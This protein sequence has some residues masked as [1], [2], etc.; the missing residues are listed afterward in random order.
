MAFESGLLWELH[1]ANQKQSYLFGTIHLN[2]SI[3]S[4]RKLLFSK[5][6][7]SCD[8]FAAEVDLDKMQNSSL[9]SYFKLP[10][11]QNWKMTFKSNQ[12]DKIHSLASRIFKIDLNDFTEIYPLLLINQL[13][14][15]LIGRQNEYSID[16]LLW[17]MAEEK[18]IEKIG[19]EDFHEHFSMIEKIQL[20][21][22]LKMLKDLMRDLKKSRKLYL[23]MIE[24][25]Q[26]QDIRSIYQL[27]RKMLGKYRKLMLTDRN[28]L[29]S[30][31]ILDLSKEKS[32]FFS[33]GAGHLYG[34]F[35][36]L[37]LLK[38]AGFQIKPMTI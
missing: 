30:D 38:K 19:L 25:Y 15:Q 16:Q 7:D 9:Q 13:S 10:V 36:I 12:W 31:R 8:L 18:G 20:P 1:F 11:D 17:E 29:I 26:C 28:R 4:E 35:G 27:S 23:K 34:G 5:I 2:S 3:F 6:L 32:G 37:R 22:Q 33:C 24:D 21:D 14:L